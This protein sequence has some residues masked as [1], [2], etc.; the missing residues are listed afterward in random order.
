MLLLKTR[1]TSLFPHVLYAAVFFSFGVLSKRAVLPSRK[2]ALTKKRNPSKKVIHFYFIYIYIFLHCCICEILG[3]HRT[4]AKTKKKQWWRPWVD[5]ASSR[6]T[7]QPSFCLFLHY[8]WPLCPWPERWGFP[9]CPHDSEGPIALLRLPGPVVCP[10]LSLFKDPRLPSNCVELCREATP[11]L[12][13]VSVI[14][15]LGIFPEIDTLTWWEKDKRLWV[16]FGSAWGV[17]SWELLRRT[18]TPC[19]DMTVHSPL[20]SVAE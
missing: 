8:D 20:F 5:H 15:E 11:S 16:C 6:L 18:R 7:P 19:K 12:F 2:F 3:A 13:S 17:R 14:I 4:K 1:L 10:F 9:H